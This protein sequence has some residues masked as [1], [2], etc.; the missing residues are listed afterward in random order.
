[1]RRSSPTDNAPER[2]TADSEARGATTDCDDAAP[3]SPKLHHRLLRARTAGL[4]PRG[5]ARPAAP[6]APSP[7]APP[8]DALDA[9]DV[10]IVTPAP[11]PEH[12]DRE[13][14]HAVRDW[15]LEGQPQR[16]D[17]PYEYEESGQH[18]PQ[19]WYKVMCLTGVDYFSTLGY[20]PGHRGARGRPAGA[21]RDAGPG[22][23]DAVRRAADVPPRR[24]GE[25]A[26]RGL[27]RD[28]GAA[29]DAGGR[30]SC[31]S[32][33]CSVSWRPTSSSR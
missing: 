15:L 7:T 13:H 26:R 2:D 4:R 32:C 10:G 20:Q 30:A 25:P 1:M 27:D 28:A 11:D 5:G 21:A 14:S 9:G 33:A 8:P 24:R 12:G 31:S 3:L 16:I 29:A 6:I 18:H 19:P 17:A 22:P 23:D